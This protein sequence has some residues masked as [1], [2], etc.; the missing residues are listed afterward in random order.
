VFPSNDLGGTYVFV[1]ADLD[2]ETK[3]GV[4]EI[5]KIVMEVKVESPADEELK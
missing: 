5:V 3:F 2:D 4:A 1:G